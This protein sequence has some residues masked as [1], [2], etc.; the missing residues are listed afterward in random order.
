MNQ[1]T[2]DYLQ[3]YNDEEYLLR[4]GEIFRLTGQF[5]APD[6]YMVLVWKANR[7]KNKHIERLEKTAG[8]FK[9]AVERIIAALYAESE[10][11]MQ[12]HILM[13]EPWQF[14]MPTAT[15]ILTILYPEEFTVYDTLVRDYL[16]FADLSY[17]AFSDRLWDDY[18]NFKKSV[19]SNTPSNLKNLRE[20][21]R[22]IIGRA[23][24]MSAEE[25]C[26]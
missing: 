22:Y 20:R 2:I 4:Q 12:L 15:A 8:S 26:G 14:L 9:I 24:R 25:V 19:I 1:K 10:A 21:D 18:E 6:F 5:S 7:A 23:N 3:F 16:D 11:K 17:R 13:S